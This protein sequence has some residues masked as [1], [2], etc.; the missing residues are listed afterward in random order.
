M[1]LK[2]KRKKVQKAPPI[3]AGTYLA[4][5]VG[6][7]DIGK[8]Y[9]A[10]FNNYKNKV[11]II[12]EIPSET[13]E[14]D[15]EQKPRWLSKEYSFSLHENSKLYKM[16][17]SWRAKDFSEEELSEDGGFQLADMAGKGCMISVT[18]T[19]KDGKRYNNVDSV[20]GLP[21]GLPVP[22]LQNDILIYDMEEPDAE[23]FEKIP[24]W[25]QDK[26]KKS[27]QYQENLPEEKM[28]IPKDEPQEGDV[29]PI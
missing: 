19:E 24:L 29:C 13:I 25:I 10:K 22:E 3:Q 17:R 11:I 7:I 1:S 15:G 21:A 2:L 9:N 16:L 4:V 12:F 18:L 8:Q 6:I 28:D 27:T 26:I 5:C 23:V 14:I 20:M